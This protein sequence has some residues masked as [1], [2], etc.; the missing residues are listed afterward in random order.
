MEGRTS[1]SSSMLTLVSSVDLVVFSDLSNSGLATM[2]VNTGLHFA[3]ALT[4]I[5]LEQVVLQ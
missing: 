1:S 2:G 3:P 5:Q 4:Q